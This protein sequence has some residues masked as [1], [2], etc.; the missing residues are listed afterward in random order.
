MRSYVLAIFALAISA[1]AA[2]AEQSTF[3]PLS[4]VVQIS[5]A[6]DVTR[7]RSRI[8]KGFGDVD[9][10]AATVSDVD[11]NGDGQISFQELMKF[12]LKG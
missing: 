6:E 3:A 10:K 2:L 9:L 11:A 5:D 7:D 1:S 8:L 12:D 4:N